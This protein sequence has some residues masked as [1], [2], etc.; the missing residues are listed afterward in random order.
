MKRV[1]AVC[2][3]VAVAAYATAA[4]SSAGATPVEKNL[5]RQ[6]TALQAQVK[7]LKKQTAQ[8]QDIGAAAVLL[9][10]CTDAVTADAF[11]GTWSVVD[12]LSAATQAGK[13]YF[14]AQTPLTATVG[15][16]DVCAAIQVA[17]SQAVPPAV[18]PYQQ[19][20]AALTSRAARFAK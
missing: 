12:Q 19:L 8:A 7:T 3:C 11:Q 17:R 1:I 5:Q 16:Q 14:G 20:L 4:W 18:T 2:A 15:G 6:I 13:T 10:A 9:T